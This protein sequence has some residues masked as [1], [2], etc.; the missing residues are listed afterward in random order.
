VPCTFVQISDSHIGLPNLPPPN[1]DPRA[2]TLTEGSTKIKRWP[3]QPAFLVPYWRDISHLSKEQGVG[4]RRS[5]H[6]N[7]PTSRCSSLARRGTTGRPTPTKRAKPISRALT[8]KNNDR[9]I[10]L[11]TASTIG[12]CALHRPDQRVRIST[13]GFKIRRPR[14]DRRR[15]SSNG[16]RRMLGPAARPS[17]PD[18]G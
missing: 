12:G 1:P 3:T 13:T 6:Q 8:A 4:R 15:G 7:R 2:E 11:V 10:G 18:R 16:W 14:Q 9:A 17:T 5:G